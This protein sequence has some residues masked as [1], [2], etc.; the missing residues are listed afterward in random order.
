[1]GQGAAI[2]G[3]AGPALAPAEAAF[4][5]ESDPWGFILFARNV[6]NP[7]QLRRLTADLREAVGRDAPVLMD[8]EG[9]RVARLRAPHW[10]EW[11][12]PLEEAAALGG[13]A[14]RGLYLRYRI[15]AGELSAVGIDANCAPCADIARPETHPVLHNRCYGDSAE[16]VA[17]LS[18]AVADGLLAGG[19]LP[20]IKHIPGHGRA[21]LDSHLE[22]PR[23]SAT[24]Q[25]LS[26]TD[27]APFRALSDLPLAMTAHIVYEGLGEVGPA[28]TS[29]A[30]IRRIR[31]R[32]GFDGLLMSDDISMQALSGPVGARAR[33]ALRAG[34]DV[35]LHC[36]GDMA[37]MQAVADAAGRLEGLARHRAD[38]ALDLRRVP[39][40]VDIAALEADFRHLRK[41]GGAHG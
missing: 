25:A 38:R 27:F 10:R 17:D 16:T 39:A 8:Q 36:N 31:D 12:P 14:R 11:P 4:F 22:L 15:I 30:M 19:V 2:F 33:A 37:E 23:V 34:V 6:E 3:C 40:P 9:G 5:R 24:E 29:P 41:D 32:I 13:N 28:T 7:G 18:R 26:E 1:M 20:V 21:T 35:I